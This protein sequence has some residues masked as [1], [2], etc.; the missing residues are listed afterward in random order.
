MLKLC[1]SQFANLKD[2]LQLDW[3]VARGEKRT[4]YQT[5]LKRQEPEKVFLTVMECGI[6]IFTPVSNEILKKA[7]EVGIC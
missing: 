7:L 6:E 5:R 2:A 1:I 3:Y 4:N